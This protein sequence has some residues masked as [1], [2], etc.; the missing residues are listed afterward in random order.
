MEPETEREQLI[1]VVLT[2]EN[3]LHARPATKLVE[4]AGKFV[5]DISI[6]KDGYVVNGKSV[7]EILTLAAEQ[8]AHLTI[9]AKGKDA[10]E[11][12]KALAQLIEGG[13]DI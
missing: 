12:V 5:S 8:G 9:T 13:F 1:V 10:A 4:A 3:G 11:A 2:H 7:I 6:A